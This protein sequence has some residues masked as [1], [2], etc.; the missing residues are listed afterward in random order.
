M[1]T[2]EPDICHELMGHAPMFIDP[3]FT[4]FSQE[5]GLAALGASDEAVK[6]LATCY[7]FTIEFGLIRQNHIPKAFGAGLLSSFGELQYCLTEKPEVRE[8]DPFVTGKQPFPITEYQPIYY[9]TDSFESM[10]EKT[11]AFAASTG[12]AFSVQY[13]EHTKEVEVIH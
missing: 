8:F 7:W 6:Q 13:N 10:A 3:A 11:R 2:P 5:L 4:K 12:R 9:I 1:Y